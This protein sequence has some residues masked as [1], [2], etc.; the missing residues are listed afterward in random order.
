MFGLGMWWLNRSEAAARCAGK[1]FGGPA[2]TNINTAN[3][4]VLRERASTS[5][6][7]DPAEL[8]HGACSAQLPSIG[9]AL[10]PL[11]VVM[12]VNLSVMVGIVSAILGRIAVVV[13]GTMFGAF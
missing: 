9:V 3:D 1:G 6:E 4:V 8:E 13:R 7:F 11:I 2:S 12:A 5:R 10:L